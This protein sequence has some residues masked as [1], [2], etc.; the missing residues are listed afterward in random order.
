MLRLS[1][2]GNTVEV[3]DKDMYHRGPGKVNVTMVIKGPKGI[4]AI[5]DSYE[6]TMI[7]LNR[8]AERNSSMLVALNILVHN[9]FDKD[10]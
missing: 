6:K 3:W 4:M 2:C 7:Q 1:D 9:E 5:Y 8:A 10:Q